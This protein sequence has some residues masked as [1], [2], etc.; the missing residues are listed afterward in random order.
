MMMVIVTVCAAFGLMVSEANMEIMCLQTKGG[1][2]VPVIVTA[3][4]QV[5][6]QTVE[7]VYLGGPISA[8]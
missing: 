7:C 2:Q 8:D 6:K 1:G 3:P 4:G 5:Y